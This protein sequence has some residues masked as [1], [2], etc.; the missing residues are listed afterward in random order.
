MPQREAHTELDQRWMRVALELAQ[1]TIGLATP[2]PRVGCVLVKDGVEIGRGAHLYDHRHHAEVVA[3]QQAAS[4]ASGATAYVTLEPCSH[5]GRTPPCAKALINAGVRRVVIATGDPNPQVS[6]RGME[7]LREAGITVT[8]GVLSTQARTLNDGFARFIRSGLPFVTLKA[9]LSLDGR[10][11]PPT[12]LR[13]PSSVAYLTGARSLLYV[14]MMRQSVDAILTGIGTVLADNPLLTDRSHRP[15]RKPLLRVVLDSQLRIPLDS[16][17][18]QTALAGTTDPTLLLCTAESPPNS[19]HTAGWHARRDALAAA[20]IPIATVT[21]T[22]AGRPDLAAVLRLLAEQYQVLNVLAEGGSELNR[23]LL[24]DETDKTG[25]G[26]IADK[27]CLFYAPTFL[28]TAGVPL[29]ASDSPLS[30][31]LQRSSIAESGSDFRLEAYLR[32]PWRDL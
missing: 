8:V 11:A 15:R 17:L 28:G 23:A 2:N 6:G 12:S 21:R 24:S 25:T 7:L 20:G 3:L 4:S 16:K 22:V 30:L 1:Q 31:E 9:A 5:T 18:V 13:Q 27:L 29:L 26:P 10:I 32:D 14:Q 19:P